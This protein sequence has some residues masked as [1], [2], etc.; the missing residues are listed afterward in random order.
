MKMTLEE[1]HDCLSRDHFDPECCTDCKARNRPHEPYE[2][3]RKA[4]EIG[5][6]AINYMLVGRKL[7]EEA[8]KK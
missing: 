8:E 3:M 7:G 1:A 4:L 6:T 5:A 2:C